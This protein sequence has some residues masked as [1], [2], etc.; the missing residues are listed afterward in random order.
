MCYFDLVKEKL[1]YQVAKITSVDMILIWLA[2]N[3]NELL[4]NLN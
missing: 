2:M 1:T 4:F 3:S